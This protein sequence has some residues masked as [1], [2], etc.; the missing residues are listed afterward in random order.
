MIR[1]SM[2]ST[3]RALPLRPP[4]SNGSAMKHDLTLSPLLRPCRTIGHDLGAHPPLVPRRLPRCAI[5]A[6]AV[7]RAFVRA[8][9]PAVAAAL[10]CGLP[11]AAPPVALAAAAGRARALGGGVCPFAVPLL[12]RGRLAVAAVAAV[13]GVR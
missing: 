6:L 9:L 7:V 3:P 8:R 10:Q 5:A 12:A 11:G 4:P 1:P 2:A 13:A